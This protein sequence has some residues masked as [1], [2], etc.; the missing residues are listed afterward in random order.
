[1]GNRGKVTIGCIVLTLIIGAGGWHAWL[2]LI[3]PEYVKSSFHD[4]LYEVAEVTFRQSPDKVNEII[5]QAGREFGLEIKAEDIK[6]KEGGADL[7]MEVTYEIPVKTPLVQKT[8][9]NTVTAT[10]KFTR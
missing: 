1:M 9:R 5:I 4:R 2:L 3:R 7:Y 8:I 6:Y 10:R